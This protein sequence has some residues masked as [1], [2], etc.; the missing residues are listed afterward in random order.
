MF[1]KMKALKERDLAN[2]EHYTGR[3]VFPLIYN[4]KVVGFMTCF[5]DEGD[6]LKDED[7][8]FVSSI[9]SLMSLCMK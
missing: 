8:D 6:A 3:I 7:I 2:H 4:K 1:S 5:L 9:A